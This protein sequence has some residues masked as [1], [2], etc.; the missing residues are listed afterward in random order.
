[1][2]GPL[3]A[4]TRPSH[5]WAILVAIA[6]CTPSPELEARAASIP[7]PVAAPKPTPLEPAIQHPNDDGPGS[8]AGAPSEPS[9]PSSILAAV[10]TEPTRSGAN[11]PDDP[12]SLVAPLDVHQRAR[13]LHGAEDPP[14]D[15]ETHYIQSNETRHDLF[16]PYID[17]VG[18]A[19]VGVGSDQNYTI[20]AKARAELMF[21]MDIDT[22]VVDLHRMYAVFISAAESPDALL[23]RWDAEHRELSESELEAGLSDLDPRHRARIVR[24]YRNGRETVFRHLQRVMARS[25]DRVPSTWLSDPKL[26]V[27]IRDLYRA[28]RVRIMVGNLAGEA[29][30]RTVAD[31]C[32]SLDTPVRVVYFSNAE[33]YFDYGRTFADSVRSLAGDTR[34]MV[35][36]TIYSQAWEHA[37]LWAYQVQPLL[38]FQTRLGDRRN[39]SRTPMLRIAKTEGVLDLRPAQEGL[40][41]VGLVG[42]APSP[43]APVPL[44]AP[45]P[46]TRV[47]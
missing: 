5:A 30:L 19:Y 8:L 12:T 24:G 35:L 28:H 42:D 15:V 44:L 20:A 14:L 21:L 29:S 40:T 7:P 11:P 23:K 2:A 32:R 9:E 43:A 47:D 1:M 31:A 22:R 38:D 13:L 17:A 45:S 25:R 37:D 41:T 46:S 27:H 33:E 26:Y 39:R 16:F 34:S 3:R 4:R 18:G 6:G 10:A 36:R